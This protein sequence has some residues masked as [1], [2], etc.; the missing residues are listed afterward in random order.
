M[1]RTRT[2]VRVGKNHKWYDECLSLTTLTKQLYNVGLYE[3]RQALLKRDTWLTD[4]ELYDLMKTN[5]N[6]KG[7]PR[8]V[9][10]QVWK[11]VKTSWHCWLK[12]L[13]VYK[14][15]PDL[16][17]SRPK[18]PSYNKSKNI[19]VYEK[20]A[21][22]IRGIPE[23]HRRLSKTSII[24]LVGELDVVEAKIIP[25]ANY[26]II[27][28]SHNIQEQVDENLD[29]TRVAG[30]D[31]GLNNLIAI[32][33]NQAGV[34]HKLVN[35]RYL[36][37]VNQRWNKKKAYLQSLLPEHQR[38]SKQLQRITQKRND[39]VNTYLHQVSRAT[40]EWLRLNRIGTVV[41]GKSVQ[42]KQNI[43]IGKRN[44]QSFVQIP[45]A[46]LID[47]ITY[48]FEAIGGRVILTEES[49]TSKAS[50]LDLDVLPVY[51]KHKGKACFSGRRIN[52]G[53][54][55][56]GLRTLVNADINGALNIIRKVFRKALA[57]LIADKQF[58]HH[59]ASPDFLVIA[60]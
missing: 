7:L 53:L 43:N 9:S 56:T 8:K 41:I 14:K 23:Q 10:N 37:S 26:F 6:W 28:V 27:S 55:R 17:L 36:K 2:I 40:V 12:A 3:L 4:K 47:L 57:D 58:I 35:G 25:K 18:M 33:T 5:E 19:V 11:Q 51:G 31:L 34:P 39:R 44:N 24:F 20:G 46:K 59:C 15:N 16:F 30:L 50:A 52:R 29:L 54:Y 42:W 13:R 32:A 21:L 49:Y 60:Q 1:K 22:N 38:V 45:H 48:K